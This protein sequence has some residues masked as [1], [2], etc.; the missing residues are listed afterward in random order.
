MIFSQDIVHIFLDAAFRATDDNFVYGFA[1]WF[2]CS[3]I[4]VGSKDDP[5][6]T[7]SEEAKAWR[8]LQP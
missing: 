8:S 6:A 2:N 1:H 3:F 5:K 7:S 4:G